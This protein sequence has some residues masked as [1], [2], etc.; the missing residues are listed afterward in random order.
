MGPILFLSEPGPAHS[1]LK[2]SWICPPGS[3]PNTI[4]AKHPST[5]TCI[6][7]ALKHIR[8]QLQ[9]PP[10]STR[11][12]NSFKLPALSYS[13]GI[14]YLPSPTHEKHKNYTI[15]SFKK[16]FTASLNL[17]TL[18]RGRADEAH[19][20]RKY[21]YSQ[22]HAYTAPIQ[23]E[24]PESGEGRASTPVPRGDHKI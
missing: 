6:I 17:E 24:A 8:A 18:P 23:P 12:D 16:F 15:S 2:N 20:Y 3:I 22:R 9:Q 19:R 7:A 4:T 11:E 14:L 21:T 13:I 5:N 1:P 10:K